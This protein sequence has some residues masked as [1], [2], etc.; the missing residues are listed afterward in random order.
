MGYPVNRDVVVKDEPLAVGSEEGD[1]GYMTRYQ[2]IKAARVVICQRLL[3]EL[4]HRETGGGYDENMD[5]SG[6]SESVRRSA[7]LEINE[8]LLNRSIR[9]NNDQP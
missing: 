4:D 6:V 5:A 9:N 8:I 7:L 2:Q 1:R 3:V